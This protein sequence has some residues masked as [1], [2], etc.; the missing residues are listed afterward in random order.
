MNQAP[1]TPVAL[2]DEL[3]AALAHLDHTR[4]RL[5]SLREWARSETAR[6]NTQ[7]ARA[8]LERTVPQHLRETPL[9]VAETTAAGRCFRQVTSILNR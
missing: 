2:L 5:E 6:A 3:T 9:P 8:L 4:A 7:E 1:P